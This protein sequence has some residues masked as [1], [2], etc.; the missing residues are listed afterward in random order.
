MRLFEI[1]IFT[2]LFLSEK[3]NRREKRKIRFVAEIA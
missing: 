2:F 3:S 1:A